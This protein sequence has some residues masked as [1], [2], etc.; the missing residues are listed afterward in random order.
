[1]VIDHGKHA[2]ALLQICDGVEVKAGGVLED[3]LLAKVGKAEG[4]HA[5]AVNI[6]LRG[7]GGA[8]HGRPW[9]CTST[10]K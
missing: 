1:M 5:A 9:H 2:G 10:S 3:V 6:N 7:W 8:V 4:L